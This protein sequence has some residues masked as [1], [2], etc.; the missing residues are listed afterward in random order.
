MS[1]PPGG[2]LKLQLRSYWP[3]PATI[4]LVVVFYLPLFGPTSSFV[5]GDY[6]DYHIPNRVYERISFGQHRLPLWTDNVMGGFPF[7]SDP[8]TAVFYPSNLLMAAMV[9]NPGRS[10]AMDRFVVAHVLIM[11]TGVTFLA[12]VLGLGGIGAV[13]AA[14]VA[15]L[16]GFFVMHQSHVNILQTC[17]AGVWGL[18][19]LAVGFKRKSVAWAVGAGLCFAAAV[20]AG[21]IQT[22]LFLFYGT[23]VGSLAYA[24]RER[25]RTRSW[26]SA[27]TILLLFGL[28]WAIALAGTVVQTLPA[29]ELVA[30]S[31]RE[32]LDLDKALLYSF[33]KRA[34]PAVWFPNLYHPF[35]WRMDPSLR[36]VPVLQGWGFPGMWEY[37]FHCGFVGFAL[38]MLGW[39]YHSR[40][41]LVQTLFWGSALIGVAS[42]GRSGLAYPIFFKVI[43]GFAQVR[44]PPRLLWLAFLAWGL[45]A[46][47]GVGALAKSEDPSRLRRALIGAGIPLAVVC[48]LGALVIC[49]VRIMTGSWEAAFVKLFFL[50]ENPVPGELRPRGSFVLD[51]WHQLAV[52]AAT[53]AVC[54]A[55]FILAGV[56]RRGRVLLG[57]AALVAVFAELFIYGFH[58]NI[59]TDDSGSQQATSPIYEALPEKPEGRVLGLFETPFRKNAAMAQD[60]RYAGGYNPIMIRW[61]TNSLPSEHFPTALM[62]SEKRMKVWNVSH[63]VVARFDVR[64]NLGGEIVSLPYMGWAQV[65]AHEE[66]AQP[67]IALEFDPPATAQR[68]RLISAAAY[69]NPQ[70]RDG[71][72]VG[73]MEV[74]APDGQQ[75]A[76][77]PIRLGIETSEWSYDCLTGDAAPRHTR[78]AT[79]FYSSVDESFCGKGSFYSAVFDLPGAPPIAKVVIRSTAARP[80]VLCVSHVLIESG[81]GR[82]VRFGVE[83]LGYEILES[84]HRD[85][86][87]LK[88][89]DFPGDAWMAP[90]ALAVS[91]EKESAVAAQIAEE[92]FDLE[93]TVLIN[94]EQM[95]EKEIALRNAKQPESF[96]GRAVIHEESPERLRIETHSNDSG[97]LV[98]SRTYYPGWRAALDGK[99]AEFLQADGAICAVAVPAGEHVVTLDFTLQNFKIGAAISGL[100]WFGAL[101]FLCARAFRR[102]RRIVWRAEQERPS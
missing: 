59:A 66:D 77:F 3:Y 26:S 81:S 38:G 7:L 31:N 98:M 62:D 89:D 64:A 45:L 54:A 83:G 67:S 100:T 48:A 30:N 79:A 50:Y 63:V 19:C 68:L 33:P 99:R 95:S 57:A 10:V 80:A 32:K 69:T 86:M 74:F 5:M 46:G 17:A 91:F 6:Q 53:V 84:R 76:V 102:F 11:A 1:R 65:G 4:F 2:N 41:I 20:L 78:L 60:L 13:V 61:L 47:L 101:A 39:R 51:V 28:S 9:P 37:L 42:F 24:I 40:S 92:D 36:W 56:L 72:E 93:K 29:R 43:P 88:R 97:W 87:V 96:A 12:R 82:A 25:G 18:G 75:I 55:L 8:Q 16:N 34:V 22:A 85:L 94:A 44:I 21:H 70:L 71:H 90:T 52:A 15:S 35:V 14:L 73:A 23:V 27:R 49:G 58:R